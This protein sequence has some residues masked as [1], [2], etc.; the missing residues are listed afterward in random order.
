MQSWDDIRLFLALYRARTLGDAAGLLGVNIS[1]VS[2]RLSALEDAIDTVLFERGR[3][4]LRP[5]PAA[6]ALVVAA[7]RVEAGVDD[8]RRSIDGFEREVRGL[9]RVAC[10]PDMA[11]VALVPA[12]GPLLERHPKL[13]VELVPGER[14]VDLARREADLA[15]RIV[16]PTEGDLVA[17]RVG[18]VA[19]VLAASPDRVRAW[20]PIDDLD[21]VPWV[22][23][24][25][26]STPPPAQ[27]LAAHV[28]REPALRTDDLRTQLTAASAGLGVALVPAPSVAAY[29]LERIALAARCAERVAPPPSGDLW[30][31]TH[32]TLRDVP[33]V[34]VVWDAMI[35][36]MQAI[37]A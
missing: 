2:R 18:V 12:L 11:D 24:G 22:A 27:W 25:R 37:V 7:E 4:G 19:M 35:E 6:D 9:V 34:A 14:T 36:V 8:V 26:A 13:R 5:T 21:A 33:R 28:T 16:R 29:G 30:I 31:V 15:L 1:T 17:R 20:G 3:H 23:W 10:P 32:R